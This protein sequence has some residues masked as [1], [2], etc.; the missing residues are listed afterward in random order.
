MPETLSP[1]GDHAVNVGSPVEQDQMPRFGTSTAV[2]PTASPGLSRSTMLGVLQPSG[3]PF[4]VPVG[5]VVGA[6][7]SGV[8]VNAVIG[9]PVTA[10]VDNLH[11]LEDRHDTGRPGVEEEEYSNH[12]YIVPS[13]FAVLVLIGLVGFGAY[14]TI[15]GNLSGESQDAASNSN[16]TNSSGVLSTTHGTAPVDGRWTDTVNA[17][18]GLNRWR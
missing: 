7:D 16:K 3:N 14:L 2:S 5:I 8:P 6:P 12:R 13:A 1:N 10:I 18:V 9:I 15:N 4:R 17:R 11:P